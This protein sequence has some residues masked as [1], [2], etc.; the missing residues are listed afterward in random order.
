MTL[1]YQRKGVKLQLKDL[2]VASDSICRDRKFSNS[3]L[4]RPHVFAH[5]SGR[6]LRMHSRT[7]FS[8]YCLSYLLTNLDFD[9]TLGVA[10]VGGVCADH[11]LVRDEKT[12]AVERRSINAGFVTVEDPLDPS[13]EEEA[14]HT[15]AHEVGHSFGASHDDPSG[16][17]DCAGYLM[18]PV[19]P[20][21]VTRKR[22]T[23][24][25]CS[26]ESVRDVLSEMRRGKR[27]WCFVKEEEKKKRTKDVGKAPPSGG[28]GRRGT[29]TRTTFGGSDKDGVGR[30]DVAGEETDVGLVAGLVAGLT[31]L[32]L[33]G[34]LVVAYA[35]VEQRF[36]FGPRS[37]SGEP[38]WLK[39]E[40]ADTWRTEKKRLSRVAS[41]A[42]R[43]S[44]RRVPSPSGKTGL[45]VRPAAVPTVKMPPRMPLKPTFSPPQ[46]SN[47][48][49]SPK[50]QPPIPA[51]ELKP[52]LHH[53]A[54][55]PKSFGD[56]QPAPLSSPWAQASKPTI[57]PKHKK[58]P[59]KSAGAVGQAPHKALPPPPPLRLTPKPREAHPN[60]ANIQSALEELMERNRQK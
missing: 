49:T 53:P 58:P 22:L 56:N 59:L 23:F 5:D 27:E 57:P 40:V 11:S 18:E 51:K 43:S 35:F 1:G 12:G 8:S 17:P 41:V 2:M 9:S 16:N 26:M 47:T 37:L 13:S 48:S 28:G 20:S 30:E 3:Y 36:C 54:S 45:F 60:V 44:I 42:R 19:A 4:C 7:D 29:K 52:S 6:F 15:M 31:V 21:V 10:Y 55:S 33:L 39:Q 25:S 34:G 38:D 46:I 32:F 50:S 14:A 24:S